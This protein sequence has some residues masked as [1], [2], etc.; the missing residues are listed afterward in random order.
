MLRSWFKGELQNVTRICRTKLKVAGQKRQNRL[1][2]LKS[3]GGK[4]IQLRWMR[5]WNYQPTRRR[6]MI[7]RSL[8]M[9]HNF[10]KPGSTALN[11]SPNIGQSGESSKVGMTVVY[12]KRNPA[13]WCNM[14]P[15]SFYS[16]YIS[17]MG[18]SFLWLTSATSRSPTFEASL[19][20]ETCSWPTTSYGG[21]H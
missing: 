3:I 16:W 13:T 21:L 2:M 12:S 9:P 6:H 17:H 15:S 14:H 5:E 10:G 19:Q 11:P 1:N 20:L 8:C 4:V 18:I 7:K